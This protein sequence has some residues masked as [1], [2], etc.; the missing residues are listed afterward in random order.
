MSVFDNPDFAG[1]LSGL[2]LLLE[3]NDEWV[4]QRAR[5]MTLETIAPFSDDVRRINETSGRMNP[6][7]GRYRFPKMEAILRQYY[8]RPGST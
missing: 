8:R 3:Q 7:S 6:K 4:E 1:A 2:R 5:Y